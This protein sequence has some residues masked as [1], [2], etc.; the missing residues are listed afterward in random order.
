M[1][2]H[3]IP[4]CSFP[5]R[6]RALWSRLTAHLTNRHL[7]GLPLT[8]FLTLL[9]GTAAA[10][11]C[12]TSIGPEF[13]AD[14]FICLTP[15]VPIVAEV[16]GHIKSIHVDHGTRVRTGDVLVQLD[17]RNLLLKRN[18]LEARIFQSDTPELYRQLEDTRLELDRLTITSPADGQIIFMAPLQAGGRL[19][20]GTAIAALVRANQSK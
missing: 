4:P 2:V 12:F 17:T 9:G 5:T 14:D 1:T 11:T 8:F 6:N 16:A 13:R 15:P 10:W 20:P 7:L 3:N 18:S 19:S